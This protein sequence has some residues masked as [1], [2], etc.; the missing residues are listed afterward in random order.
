MLAH[1]A[2]A[3][4][5]LKSLMQIAAADLDAIKHVDANGWVSCNATVC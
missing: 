4:G 5:D 2:A 3:D 1:V